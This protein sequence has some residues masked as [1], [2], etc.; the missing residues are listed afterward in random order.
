MV[1]SDQRSLGRWGIDHLDGTGGDAGRSMPAIEGRMQKS[2]ATNCGGGVSNNFGGTSSRDSVRPDSSFSSSNYS[3]NPRR[4]LLPTP[5]KLKSDTEPLN[6]RLGPPDFYPQTPHC[7]EETLTREYLQAGYKD[8]VEGIEEAKEIVLS[9]LGILPNKIISSC[10]EAIRKRHK[11]IN[12]SRAQKRKA[13][14]VYGVPLSGSLL[15]KPGFP[16]QKPC[17]EDFRKKW[18]EGLSQQHKRLRSL[19]DHIPLGYRKK[20]LF[21]ILIRHNVPLLRATW[22]IKVTYL[23]QIRPIVTA[24]SPGASGKVQLARSELWTKDVIDYLQYLLDDFSS[25]DGSFPVLQNRDQ[26]LQPVLAGSAQQK[27]DVVQAVPG[28]EEPSLQFK[29]WYMVRLLQ[30]HHTEGLLLPSLI[31]EWVLSQ[32]QEKKLLEALELLLPIVSGMIESIALSQTYVRMFVDIAV[33]FIHDLSSCSS[34]SFD[35]PRKACISSAMVEMLRYLILAVPDTFVALDCFP[36]PICL[37]AD[38]DKARHIPGEHVNMYN[39][40][41]Y[42]QYQSLGF[43]I[44]SLRKRAA[45]LAKIVNPG[46]QGDGV[47][48][49]VQAL[50]KTLMQGDVRGAYHCLFDDKYDGAI[51]ET[52]VAEVSPLLHSSMKWI[53]TASLSMIR[54]VFFLCEWATCDYR[55]Y[56]ITPPHN[57]KFTGRKDFCSVYVAVLL[58]RL[59]M[60]DMRALSK[61]G[62]HSGAGNIA[63]AVHDSFV[64]NVSG[65][66]KKLK[67]SGES[68]D[69]Y[70]IFQSPGPLHDIVVCWLDQHKV[71][72]GESFK[73][74][75]VLIMELIRFGIFYPQSYVRQLIVSGIMER[76]ETTDDLDRQ[77]R[78]HRILK[79]LPG[80]HLF[81]VLEEARIAEVPVLID[82]VRVYTNERH[83]ILHGLFNSYSEHLKTENNIS[84]NYFSNNPKDNSAIGWDGTAPSSLD[85]Q[86]NSHAVFSPSS[87]HV[88]AKAY[89][90]ELKT[91]ISVLLH[92]P[93]S[94]NTSAVDNPLDKSHVRLRRPIGSLVTKIDMMEGTVGCEECRK[95]KRQKPNDERNSLQG[96]S[97]NISDDEGTWWVQKGCKSIES[98]KVEL[99]NR[100]IKQVSRGRR[101]TQSVTQLHS[102]RIEGS[103]GASTSH[104]CDSK[105]VC[106]HHKTVMEVENP[107][108]TD[109]LR[110]S[111]LGD[112]GKT[113]KRLRW[114]E[115]RCIT[116]W[117]IK[118]IKSLVQSSENVSAKVSHSTGQFSPSVDEKGPVQWKL[119]EDELL[120]ILYLLDVSSDLFAAAK[121]LLWLFP[122]VINAS[123]SALHVGRNI[124]TMPK[125]K[126]NNVCEVSEA[127]LLS[128]LLRYENIIVASDL[129]PEVLSAVMHHIRASYSPTFL[130]ARN[131]LKKYG[132]VSSVVKWEKNFKATCDQR[133]L[134]ELEAIKPVD[135]DFGFSV[136]NPSGIEDFD[137]VRQKLFGRIS[138]VMKEI[139]QKHIEDALHYLYGKERKFFSAA[140]PGGPGLEKLDDGYHIAQQIVLS[141]VDCFRQNGVSAQEGDPALVASAI[142][143]I[144]GN[145]GPTVAKM[146]DFTLNN[147]FTSSPSTG[148]WLYCVQRVIHIHI[149]CL[150]LLKEVLGERQAR[151][152]EIALAAEASSTVSGAFATGKGPRSQFHPSPETHDPSQNYSNDKNNSVKVLVGR[153]A[154][155]AAAVSALV[156]GAV[157]HGVVSL[158]RIVA[159]FKLKDGLDILQYL[160]NSRSSSNGVPR[161]VALKLENLVELYVHWFMVLIGNCRTVADGLVAE[162]LGESY[163]LALS[164]MQRMLPLNLVFPPAYSIFAMVIWRP[165]VL[166]SNITTLEDSQLYQY[167]SAAIGDAIRH[168]P[169]RDICLHDTCALYDLLSS[170]AGDSEFAALLELR[171]PDK[172]LK[173]MGFVPLRAR[174]FLSAI[175]DWKMPQFTLTKD[176]GSCF[177]GRTESQSPENEKKPLDQ[178]VHVLDT[179]QPAK[180]HWQWVELRLL[181]NEQTMIEKIEAGNISLVEAI[182]S[183]SPKTEDASLS[184]KEN[185]FT[186]IVMRGLLV[187]PDAAPLYSEVFHLLGKSMEEK[188]LMQSK[189]LLGGSDVLLGR[190]SIRQKLIN[191]ATKNR[192]SIKSQFWKPWGWSASTCNPTTNRS[193]KRKL[194]VTSIEEGE[195]VEEGTDIK[196]SGK[197]QMSDIECVSSSQQYVTEKALTELVLPCIDRSSSELRCTFAIEL[198]KQMKIIEQHINALTPGASKHSGPTPSGEGAT[199]KGSTRKGTRG[200]SPGM[201][202][203]LTGTT[204]STPPSAA[205]LRASMSLRL[206]F[207]LRL[208]PVIYADRE[209]SGRNM[210][211]LLASVIIRLLGSRVVYED[212]ADLSVFPLARNCVA[213]REMDSVMET[214]VAPSGDLSGDSLFDRFLYVLHGLLSSCKPSWLKPK[215]ASKSNAKSPREFPVD[216]EVA[217]A[218]QS[219][220]DRLQVPATIR[221][222]IQAAMP[223]LPSSIPSSISYQPPS[224]ST[225]TLSSMQSSPSISTPHHAN[226]RSSISSARSANS[227]KSN[228][229]PS[230]DP[231]SEIDPW[232][233]L[234]DGTGSMP[235][236]SSSNV[237]VSADHCDPKASSLLKGAVRMRR[238]ELTYIGTVDDDG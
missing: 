173:T 86:R 132:N 88:K 33:H 203:R 50:D 232:T 126:E 68:E 186:E 145:V 42:S 67:I 192:L 197:I 211:H 134:A 148:S 3:L 215:S 83:L 130:Y 157:I 82:A 79:Q 180:F 26:P 163:M 84:L 230:Q 204:D 125:N 65:S 231:D 113:L 102:A 189:W 76:N 60:E 209:P 140:T 30:W 57:V 228:P 73:R 104:V 107:K 92:F 162:L 138:R 147:N 75:H 195:F 36:L 95:M 182:R 233:V 117:L 62:I 120:S 94:Y 217:E 74:L 109:G 156:V 44:S 196:R 184:E 72:K 66:R 191:Y 181:L 63:T 146:P 17:G 25:K 58:L 55:D 193:E 237:G 198:I 11:A 212:A 52:W 10:K 235:A 135:G 106:P 53:G 199:Q 15:S 153:T 70:D 99:P 159:A 166:N 40:K 151:V 47:A 101:K 20:T 141:L 171:S 221:W 54:S 27:A 174:L 87:Q 128:S 127:F 121:F 116:I 90:M 122:R 165:Y 229:I 137:N 194:E 100:S 111:Q 218:L 188:L 59:R 202:R 176:G 108:G 28:G 85:S 123:S 22:F 18:I 179:L 200:G 39:N 224:M 118:S 110:L 56:R 177:S 131:L 175:V 16:E 207:L 143:A 201:G 41:Q 97:S 206:Q 129:L 160:R 236:A 167:L 80:V 34:T 155:A 178:L 154:K 31:I 32:L 152:F 114:L 78:H 219:E 77:K 170:D 81:D 136:G 225:S 185:S 139:V 190:K 168:Q 223:I 220:L 183:M 112:I 8:S 161:S 89:I 93:D 6:S 226:V 172:L 4:P 164:R 37:V 48:K 119:G 9:Q 124:L 23:N 91:A 12:E 205:A 210:R 21:D 169:F 19:A 13:G 49:V 208:L 45:N 51:Q 64:D 105:L 14:Q 2:Y 214:S 5:Y 46:L 213:E 222:R 150:C 69:R 238:T 71:G 149:L 187:R 142:S 133:I 115:K 1:R 144:V 35:N 38:I 234:E 103:Q 96:L 24:V 7:P 43:V 216:R 158:E 61:N 98:S 29:W 227:A